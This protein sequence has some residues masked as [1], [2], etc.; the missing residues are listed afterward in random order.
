[1]VGQGVGDPK[2]AEKGN[3]RK[4]KGISP[5]SIDFEIVNRVKRSSKRRPTDR[6]QKSKHRNDQSMDSIDVLTN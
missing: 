5:V 1:M 3:Q 4:S 6:P 2:L